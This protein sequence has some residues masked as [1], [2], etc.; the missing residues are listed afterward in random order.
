LENIMIQG[1]D[2]VR[3]R[4]TATDYEGDLFEYEGA[5]HYGGGN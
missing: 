3:F 1:L 4:V 5:Y 2:S